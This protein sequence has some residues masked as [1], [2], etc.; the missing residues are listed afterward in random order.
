MEVIA[1]SV[2]TT[3]LTSATPANGD[4]IVLRL[5]PDGRIRACVNDVLVLDTTSTTFA[6]ETQVGL[7]AVGSTVRFDDVAFY[8]QADALPCPPPPTP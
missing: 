5:D 2:G 6:G 1:G 4:R 3:T 8:T 7:A